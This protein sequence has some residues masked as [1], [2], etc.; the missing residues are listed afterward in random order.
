MEP[1]RVALVGDWPPPHGGVSVHVEALAR[2]L[3]ARGVDV[4]V[5][6]IGRGDHA[7]ENVRPAR[8]PARYAAALAGVAA[9]GRLVHVHTNGANPK[10]WLVAL[11][12][13]RARRPAAPRG[14][15]TIH[16]GLCP[17]WL[18]ASPRRRGLAAW[19]CAAYARVVAVSGEVAGA[20]A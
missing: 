10:S 17:A 13:G 19:A 4:R 20:L 6:D 18:A 9:E 5:L 2:D 8:G 7:R 11:A 12:G 3:Q 16:S 14:V 1:L 15:L